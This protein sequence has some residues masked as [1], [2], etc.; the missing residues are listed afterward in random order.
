M[1]E[2]TDRAYVKA[3]IAQAMERKDPTGLVI[4]FHGG[5]IGY[6]EG[7]D[8]AN[9]LEPVYRDGGAFPVF[10]VWESGL[11]EIVRNNL[12]E[13]AREHLFKLLWKRVA[14]MAK[15]KLMQ[16]LGMKSAGKL[17]SVS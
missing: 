13:L 6:N 1:K 16:E 4:H 8:I 15:R 14:N 17:P 2:E 9:K 12:G 7:I 5:L 11:W 3:L 10:F